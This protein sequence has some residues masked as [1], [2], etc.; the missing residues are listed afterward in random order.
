MDL[1]NKN[2]IEKD[3]WEIEFKIDSTTFNN[4]INKV[5]N[6]N[7]KNLN[8]P[9]FRKGK[10]PI[11]LVEKI[12]GEKI[13][14]DEAI[15]NLLPTEY[16]QVMD[17]CELE[18]VSRPQIEIVSAS[19]EEGV[20]VKAIVFTKPEINVTNYKGLDAEKTVTKIT[21]KQVD[22]EIEKVRQQNGRI[23]VVEDRKTKSGDIAVIDFEGF[24]DGVAFPGGAGKNHPLTLG[25]GQFIPGFEEQVENRELNEEFDVNVT[26]PKDYHEKSLA[27]KPCVFKVKVNEIKEI[28]LADLD[29]EFAKDVSE[30]DTLDDYKKSIKSKLQEEADKK[31]KIELENKLIEQ[32]IQNIE[33]DIPEAM[34]DARAYDEMHNFEHR[35]EA[36]GMDINLYFKYT[37]TSKEM[38]MQTFR[39]QAVNQV[40]TKLALEKIVEIEKLDA[41]SEEIEAEYEKVA[42]K[43]N[44]KIEDVKKYV[45]EKDIKLD[46][47]INKAVDLILDSAK[48]TEVSK[49]EKKT[50][51][52]EESK[53][54]KTETKKTSNTVKKST[55]NKSTK[56]NKEKE[57]NNTK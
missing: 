56:N 40:K 41:T 15:D 43:S 55:S 34:Y 46:I 35:L 38:L 42:K 51:A 5:Y 26:F 7:K 57:V 21:N 9:G 6:K 37:G 53:T 44:M 20:I 8:V 27:D 4:A 24:C 18:I 17:T 29:D 30:F 11:K 1:L 36:Q 52:K 31:S 3:K 16:K 50:K 13:F 2:N 12:Y 49:D 28:Q 25:S 10:A 54:K 45:L 47:C 19:K 39:S 33:G 32:V 14:F 22:A 48:I 23:V